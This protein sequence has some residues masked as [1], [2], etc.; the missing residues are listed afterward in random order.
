MKPC[1]KSLF[2]IF[3]FVAVALN[4]QLQCDNDTTGLVSLV[5]LQTGFYLGE[6]QGGL[7]HGGSNEMPLGHLKKGIKI[8]KSI[9]PLDSLG[10]VDWVNGRV[11]M[12]CFGP[13]TSVQPFKQYQQELD[14]T[15]GLNN[16]FETIILNHVGGI[17]KMTLD[18]IDYWEE[19]DSVKL[20]PF[21]ITREQIQIGWM[22]NGSRIDSNY[23]MPLQAD[24]IKAKYIE[25]FQAL[26]ANYPN[27]QILYLSPPYYSGYADPFDENY[28]VNQEPCAYHAGFA[29]KWAIEDQMM[30]SPALKYKNPG[31]MA[32]F[33]SWG[34]H[35]WADGLRA[36]EW[37]GLAWDCGRYKPD[38]AGI[39]LNDSG[40]EF[41]G[42]IIYDFFL[43]DTIAGF[44]Y[45][46]AAKWAS[47][48]PSERKENEI[49]LSE[50]ELMIYPNPNS[51]NFYIATDLLLKDDYTLNIINQF[52]QIMYS[53]TNIVSSEKYISIETDLP[54]GIYFVQ[55]MMQDKIMAK[56]FVVNGR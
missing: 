6:F 31:A 44:W 40:K 47:C 13:S 3:I 26:K 43:N 56:E 22:M 34:P 12:A 46:D 11:I 1:K 37:D 52:G 30:G 4:A 45:N 5:D 20:I 53:E 39:H 33:L 9:K 14:G 54:A 10:N 15:E 32:P 36:N 28:A 25:T 18:N 16:C 49:P 24:S 41:L 35:I 21:G 27:L 29:T 8:S 50:N 55:L 48:V 23:E 7:Y 2:L 51:G 19:I 17:E 42:H 38:G